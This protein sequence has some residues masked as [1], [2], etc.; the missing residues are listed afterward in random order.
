MT[1]KMGFLLSAFVGTL[2]LAAISTVH[3]QAP[4]GGQERDGEVG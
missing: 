1:R 2:L 4:G 3:A